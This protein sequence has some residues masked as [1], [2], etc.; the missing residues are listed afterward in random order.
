M[1]VGAAGLSAEIRVEREDWHGEPELVIQLVNT[2]PDKIPGLKDTHLYETSLEV[3]GL[4]TTPFILESL[5]D[6]FRYDR[7]IPAYGINVGVVEVPNHRIRS[8]QQ[9][10]W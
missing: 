9:T 7:R 2:S 8:G 4:E 6:S 5:P 1:R 3:S 10:P